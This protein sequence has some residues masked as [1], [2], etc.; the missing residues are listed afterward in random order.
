MAE[1]TKI[2]LD[3]PSDL[4]PTPV[5]D[6]LGRLSHEVEVCNGPSAG[7]VCPI[8]SGDGCEKVANAS[9]IIYHLDLD[10]PQHQEILEEYRRS[11]ATDVPLLVVV[12][13]GQD[14]TY[15]ELLHGLSVW[16][17]NPTTADLDGFAAMV[18]AANQ[19]REP[20]QS[21]A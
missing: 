21:L 7:M 13:P 6:F 18:E 10:R 3:S 5:V 14:R 15:A 17:H 9:G 1:P 2:L 16:T 19:T 12:Q 4:D 8:L 11:V 20:A